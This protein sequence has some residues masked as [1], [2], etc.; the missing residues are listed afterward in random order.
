MTV[1]RTG[2][3]T[4]ALWCGSNEND[5][6]EAAIAATYNSVSGV[7]GAS[8]LG[9]GCTSSSRRLSASQSRRLATHAVA[10]DYTTTFTVPTATAT[11][12]VNS[13]TAA[14][15]ILETSHLPDKIEPDHPS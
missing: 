1:D 3:A 14:G 11:T 7:S 5:A 9:A 13:L 2:Y 15:G 12:V 6:Y 4:T 8:T 10:Y